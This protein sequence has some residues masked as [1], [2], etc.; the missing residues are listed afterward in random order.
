MARRWNPIWTE[1]HIT[2]A[3]LKTRIKKKGVHRGGRKKVNSDQGGG[4]GRNSPQSLHLT[5]VGGGRCISLGESWVPTR[6][7]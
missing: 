1:E 7:G 5:L 4:E 2:G 3:V 6:G